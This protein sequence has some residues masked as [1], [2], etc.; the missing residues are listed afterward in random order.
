MNVTITGA[1]GF[2]GR[3]LA[4]VLQQNGHQVRPLSRTEW[5]VTAA[6]PPAQSLVKADAIVHLAGEP[7]AQRWTL[8]AKRKILD[9]RVRGTHNIVTALSTLSRRPQ[10]MVCAS[11]IGIYGERGDE[12]LTE[13]S[14]AGSGFL[15]DVCKE[16]EQQADLAA[17]LG[18]RVVK[19][20]TGIVLGKNG[21]ALQ[22][23]LPPFRAFV[24]GKIGSGRQ[25]MSWIHLDD[26]VGVIRYAME[27][28]LSGV[29]NG[30]AP[31]PAT[32][33]Q[34]TGELA[35]AL[36][37][38]ALFP[39]PT[40][41]LK[42]MFGEMSEILLSS[43]RVLPKAAESGGYRFRFPQLREALSELL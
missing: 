33:S 36:H 23:M 41:A 15:A 10:V 12:L 42:V 34:F 4:E 18:M 8:E 28:P 40:F 30:T 31:N 32:N 7:V 9:S 2:I 29:V 26:L 38:P 25:W 24:G 13:S 17:S 1:T 16:W 3:R 11:A 22:K 14:P 27:H 6:E 20:R 21:G 19:L 35:A 5:N 37:R 43:Q 39:V